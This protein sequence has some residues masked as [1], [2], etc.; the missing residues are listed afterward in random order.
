VSLD[1][2]PPK[3]EVSAIDFRLWLQ[4]DIQR[5]STER[6]VMTQTGHSLHTGDGLIGPSQRNRF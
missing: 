5:G 3:A 1:R 4:A 6:P 2:V